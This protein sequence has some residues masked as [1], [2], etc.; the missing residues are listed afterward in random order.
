MKCFV[1]FLLFC[2]VVTLPVSAGYPFVRG[3]VNADRKVDLA[4]PVYLLSALFREGAAI[5]CMKAADANDDGEVNLSDA[6]ALLGY[7]FSGGT[8]PVAPFPKWGMDPTDD[9]LDCQ[10]FAPCKEY[11]IENLEMEFVFVEPG[12][13]MMGSDALEVWNDEQPVHEVTLTKGFYMGKYEVTNGQILTYLRDTGDESEI[14]L[15]D[16]EYPVRRAGDDYEL[17]GNKFGQSVDQPM[18][19]ISWHGAVAFCNWLTERERG[20]GRIPEDWTFRLSTEAEWEYAARGGN[21]S[22]GYKYSGSD[23]IDEVAWYESNSGG[24]THDVGG[25]KPNELSIYDMTGNVWE[26]CR[27]RYGNIY[28]EIS[29]KADPLGAQTGSNRVA[30]GGSWYVST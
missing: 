17:S 29:P 4:D 16:E 3:D 15:D 21:Q 30:R 7:F 22:Q 2:F 1:L 27:D 26:W 12:T 6:A 28:Y 9:A 8:P 10:E 24:K 18:V 14:D 25:K 11:S 20:V 19:E 5:P 23:N 13:F